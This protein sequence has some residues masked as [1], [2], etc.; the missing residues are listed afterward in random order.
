MRAV[1]AERRDVLAELVRTRLS[2]LLEPRVPAGGMQM[3]C[4]FVRDLPEAEAVD[5]AHRAGIDLLGLS[6]LSI[7]DASTPGFLMGFAAHA[8][9]ELEAGIKTLVKVLRGLGR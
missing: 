2:G 1:Y 9:P 4:V 8:P 5:A 6:T 3:P 7:A